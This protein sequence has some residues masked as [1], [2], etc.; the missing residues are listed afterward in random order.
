MEVTKVALERILPKDRSTEIS[1]FPRGAEAVHFPVQES[2]DRLR[3]R[4][5]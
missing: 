1:E 2:R 3:K 4:L 5:T